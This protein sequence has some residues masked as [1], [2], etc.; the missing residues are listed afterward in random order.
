MF[1]AYY[2]KNDTVMAVATLGM[3]NYMMHRHNGYCEG[4]RHVSPYCAY[5]LCK[6]GVIYLQEKI[7][8]LLILQICC[9][10]ITFY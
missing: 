7:L 1:A 10:K 8:L 4:S 9:W 2:L 3:P 5:V 6:L